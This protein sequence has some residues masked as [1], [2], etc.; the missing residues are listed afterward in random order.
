[1]WRC[2]VV[3]YT[4][5]L[6]DNCDLSQL[7]TIVSTPKFNSIQALRAFAVCL[8][9]YAHSID[10]SFINYGNSIQAS[11]LYLENWGAIGLDLFFVIS[12]FI[13]TRI[14]HSYE[15]PNGWKRFAWKR[16]IRIVPTYWI[17]SLVAA[18][19]ILRKSSIAAEVFLKTFLFFP[20]F[21]TKFV[22]P[23]LDVGWSLS[24]EFYFYL[25]ITLILVLGFKKPELIICLLLILLSTIGVFITTTSLLLRFLSSPIL[26]EFAFGVAC[27]M[28]LDHFRANVYWQRVG[29]FMAFALGISMM[30]GSVFWGFG[31]LSEA[32][33]VVNDNYAAFLRSLVWGLPCALFLLGCVLLERFY[34]LTIPAVLVRIGD[35]SYSNYL[36]HGLIIVYGHRLFLKMHLTADSYIIMLVVLCTALSIVF[37]RLVE[38]PLTKRL[39]SFFLPKKS[40]SNSQ[41]MHPNIL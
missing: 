13:M 27:G 1:M 19:L 9:I 14:I 5:V 29:M 15:S 28:I 8:V 41:A 20:I 3:A 40:Y 37:Y 38:K 31:I 30:I 35:A 21:E 39:N 16:I 11:F 2:F 25:L 36:L 6:H 17:I 7:M 22:F 10:S 32:V 26:L 4:I 12:G 34:S 33:V 18:L 24:Y 23:V